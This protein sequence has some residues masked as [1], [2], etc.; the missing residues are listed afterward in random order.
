M[1]ASL[2]D[3]FRFLARSG[4]RE[5]TPIR[6]EIPGAKTE[7]GVA[8]LRLYDPIDSWGEFWGVSAKE[9]VT[10]LDELPDDTTEIRLHI[11]SPG[12]EVFEGIAI[13]N[14]LRAHKANVVMVVDGLAASAA[15][16]IAC[17]GDELVMAR[18]SELMIHDAW[19]I[20]VG[21]AADMQKMAD[22]LGH[23]SDNLASVYA[24]KSGGTVE[25]WRAAMSAETWFSAEEAVLAG[26]ADRV[27]AQ[28]ADEQAKN[29]FD[30]SVFA[31]AGREKAPAPT[32]SAVTPK[33]PAPP[34]AS[35]STNTAQEA[36]MSLSDALRER[37][38]IADENADEATLLA[39]LDE[40]LN[41]QATPP[42]STTEEVT[43]AA[44]AEVTRLSTELAELKASAAKRE[45][46]ER[47]AAWLRDGKTSP[48]ERAQL[49]A[50]YDAAPAQTAALVDARAK[51]SV[52]PVDTIGHDDGTTP[53]DEDRLLAEL[54]GPDS[55]AKVG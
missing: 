20:C 50:M 18:N 46:D 1:T 11:N 55:I 12:G 53:S 13:M 52:V 4:Q 9:F 24:E 29:R 41:E 31:Y 44:L 19:G 2:T 16:F 39:A 27:D 6:A 43:P 54:F 21:N 5:K 32:A 7:D 45:K 49:E 10:A 3:R 17:S 26:L 25:D 14:A 30:L 42:K 22:D 36:E 33:T 47:F 40:A 38:G 8:V 35:G 23:F 51:G 48:A 34:S 15:S 28:P 37:L